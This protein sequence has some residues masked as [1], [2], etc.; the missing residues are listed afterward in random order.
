MLVGVTNWLPLGLVLVVQ[1]AVHVV[2]FVESHVR[3]LE[4]PKAIVVG[5]GVRVAV[6][7]A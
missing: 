1:G 4:P 2:E 5:F 7:V 3:V 6:G